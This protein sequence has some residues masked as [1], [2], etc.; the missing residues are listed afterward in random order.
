MTSNF[1]TSSS[2]LIYLFS[3]LLWYRENQGKRITYIGGAKSDESGWTVVPES[4]EDENEPHPS[5]QDGHG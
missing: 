4:N 2:N 3:S 1:N 5:N